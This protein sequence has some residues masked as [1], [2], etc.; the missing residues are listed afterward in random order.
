MLCVYGEVI[1]DR[2]SVVSLCPYFPSSPILSI[3]LFPSV[4]DL[5]PFS[6]YSV[7]LWIESP[8]HHV[9]EFFYF[10]F[11][12]LL[13]FLLLG[14]CLLLLLF[15]LYLTVAFCSL[16]ILKLITFLPYSLMQLSD[17]KVMTLLGV[18]CRTL[19]SFETFLLSGLCLS[20]WSTQTQRRHLRFLSASSLLT[21]DLREF[22]TV[23]THLLQLLW[24]KTKAVEG[25]LHTNVQTMWGRIWFARG[26]A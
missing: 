26:D 9:I 12:R 13:V 17:H 1:Q 22:L 20:L 4:S 15:S 3:S 5:Q 8:D 25:W 21:K 23:Q 7:F 2:K 16:F 24:I 19:N 11:F 18:H 10:I 14:S 6:Q